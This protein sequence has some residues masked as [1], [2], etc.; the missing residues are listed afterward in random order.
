[1]KV[2]AKTKKSGE[3]KSDL[4]NEEKNNILKKNKF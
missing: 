1:M 2:T 4:I 3:N